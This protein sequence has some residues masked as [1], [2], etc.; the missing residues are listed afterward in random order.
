[1]INNGAFSLIFLKDLLMLSFFSTIRVQLFLTTLIVFSFSGF[2]QPGLTLGGHFVPK[3]SIMVFINMGNSAMSGRDPSPDLVTEPH[4]W[5]FE[6]SPANHDWLLAKEPI[7]NDGRNTG[8]MGGPIMPFLKAMHAL[9][10]GFY[11]GVMQLSGSA[12]ELQGH[13]NPGAAD[14][15]ALLTQ[16][17]LLK[18]NVTIAGIV[19]MLNLVEVQNN[20][21]ANYAQKVKAMVNNIRTNLGTLQYDGVP[22]TVPYIHAGYPVMAGS[23]YDTSLAVTKA[24]IKQIA[25]IPDSVSDC[26]IIPTEGLT[27]CMSGCITQAHYDRAGNVGW[28]N[29]TADTVEARSWIPP[30]VI[31]DSSSPSLASPSNGATGIAINPTLSWNAA[32][33]A[34]S[35]MVRVSTAPDFGTTVFDRSGINALSQAVT[36]DLIHSTR[37]YWQVKAEN[38]GGTGGYSEI[39]SFT[40]IIAVPNSVVLVSPQDKDSSITT[41]SVVLKWRKATQSVDKYLIMV[42]TDSAMFTTGSFVKI[43]STVTDTIEMVK[44][45]AANQRYWWKVK[46]HNISGWGEFSPEYWFT[47]G[48][49]ASVVIPKTYEVKS[50]GLSGTAGVLRY[51]LPV[52]CRVSVN[53][54]NLKGQIMGVFVN[55]VQGA[56]VYSLCLPLSSW[57]KGSYIQEFKAGSFVKK[58]IITI[59]R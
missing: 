30:A 32:S 21:A 45:I 1:V 5:K 15:N 52:K 40:T 54:Y 12:W 25:M 9:Y 31:S 50:A 8:Q 28:G 24:I 18:P 43:D 49:T 47:K 48:G 14:V 4:L 59:V 55:Q 46:A 36:P 22:Y 26:V 20:H 33:G 3:D 7:C 27:I 34:P 6:M 41:D 38:A 10:P 44:P 2:A 58:E 37:Y 17:N 39:W 13:F 51:A 56:G 23:G 29:R 57:A 19:S 53:Y 35:Y 11:F 16:A 42:S